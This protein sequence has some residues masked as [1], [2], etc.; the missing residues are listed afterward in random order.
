MPAGLLTGRGLSEVLPAYKGRFLPRRHRLAPWDGHL[1][2]SFRVDRQAMMP[3]DYGLI[4]MLF[5]A[6]LFVK[7]RSGVVSRT[8]AVA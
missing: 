2:P 4:Q 7:S 1:H 8:P 5:A 3:M 6:L